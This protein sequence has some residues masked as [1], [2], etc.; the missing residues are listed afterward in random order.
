[1]TKNKGPNFNPEFRLETAQLVV[2]QGYTNREAAEAMG[3]GYSTLGKWVKQLREE[4][5]GKTPQASPM[6]PEQR[7]IRELKKQIERLE[8]EK[9]ILKK[10]FCSVDV[11]LHETLSLIEK[12]SQSN[13]RRYSV[14]HLCAVL[15]VHRSTFKYWQQRDKR[16]SPEAIRL[17]SLVREAYRLSGG[18]AGARTISDI[19]TN[20]ETHDI[21]L[22][23]YRAG[24]FMKALSLFSC[25]LP[26]H[27]YR[28]ATQEHVAIP[29]LLDRQFAVTAP[30][31]VWCGDVSFIWT[32]NRWA[33]LAVVIDLFARKPIGWAMSYSPDSNL[34]SQALTMAFE[35]RGQPKNV[36]FHSDQGCH[37]TS[38]KFR[39]LI[40]R[41][42]LTQSMSRRGNCW[43]NSPMERFFRSLKTEWVPTTGYVSFT[44]AKQKI[45]DYI[46]GYYSRLRPHSYNGGLTPNE[47]EKR[48]W[49]SYNDVAK[50]T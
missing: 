49:N 39:Q 37:Y 46:H 48:Y 44:E 34:T 24:K 22:S 42:R 47:S 3:V 16:P 15:D 14:N 41:Y 1:M 17:R 32:G 43:D 6:T 2:D 25:Q 5:A 4:R 13:K 7:E 45:G 29:N 40:W 35:Y 23:R 26:K 8:L 10:A 11:G 27:T 19:I 20:D 28:K 38:R 36:M 12:L 33:Y 50:M 18:S 30:D 31:Q 9:E 21:T